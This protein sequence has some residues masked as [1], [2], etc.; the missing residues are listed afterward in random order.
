MLH[1]NKNPN[2]KQSSVYWKDVTVPIEVKKNFHSEG[3]LIPQ[4]ARYARAIL[5]EQFDRKFAITVASSATQCRLF[6]WDSV[7]CH[8][9]EIID[10][11]K[12]PILFIR[13]IARL[14]M[15]TP[16][17]LGYDEHFSNAG[18]VLSDQELTTTLTVHES[19]IQ[20]YLDTEAGSAERQPNTANS[21]LLELDTK[22]FLFESRGIL[23]HRH[24][25]VWRGKEILDKGTWR[26]GPTRVVKQ[27]WAEDT[28]PCE[29]YFYKLTEQIHTVS[30]LL[31]MEECDHTWAY[32]NRVTEQDVIGYLKATETKPDRQPRGKAVPRIGGDRSTFG[33]D[34]KHDLNTLEQRSRTPLNENP[35][36][37]GT[38]ERVL[39]RFVFE[40]EHRPLSQARDSKE[41]MDATVQWIEVFPKHL[42][43]VKSRAWRG[44]LAW[45]KATPP[46]LMLGLHVRTITSL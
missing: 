9:T 38:L 40:E 11:H 6:H 17:E 8:A 32:H 16:A 28:R 45:V 27:N 2:K 12:N 23:F 30:S 29:G 34:P 44:E 15:M 14:A 22:K 1:R 3:E 25:R 33:P 4:V 20:R 18:R 43:I 10:I 31:L 42:P 13:C 39:L 24:T 21:K 7:G 41:V 35:K 36:P 5:M 46:V 37:V 26:T 19:P